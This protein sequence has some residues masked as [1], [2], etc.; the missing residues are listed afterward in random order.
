MAR[1]ALI[2]DEVRVERVPNARGYRADNDDGQLFYETDPLTPAAREALREVGCEIEERAAAAAADGQFVG[3]SVFRPWWSEK[4]AEPVGKFFMQ[5]AA[6]GNGYSGNFSSEERDEFELRSRNG[7]IKKRAEEI[8]VREIGIADIDEYWEKAKLIE[9][10][11]D[12]KAHLER[13]GFAEDA[14]YKYESAN[15]TLLYEAV[16]FR[17]QLVPTKKKFIPRYVTH[18]GMRVGVG[19]V[20][21]PYRL[22]ELVEG[23]N[24]GR[25]I[26]YCE[27]EKD[28]DAAIAA[29][30]RATTVQGSTLDGRLRAVLGGRGRDRRARQRRQGAREREEGGRGPHQV[31]RAQRSG[32]RT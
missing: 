22:E 10:W 32:A 28:A 15:G 26:F 18:D 3:K 14:T 8:S 17:H 11:A 5:D 25:P 6:P 1:Q 2:T 4:A 9:N 12:L 16:K 27:G 29:G 20:R 30:L 21:V 7:R 31:G 19:P 13:E 23:R 24:S